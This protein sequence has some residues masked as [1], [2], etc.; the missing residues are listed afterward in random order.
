LQV[1]EDPEGA[2]STRPTAVAVFNDLPTEEVNAK[3]NLQAAGKWTGARGI[4]TKAK[5]VAPVGFA[6][7][8]DEE[9]VEA[10]KRAPV[11]S[12]TSRRAFERQALGNHRAAAPVQLL[13]DFAREQGTS[14]EV[15][16]GLLG[17]DP[18]PVYGST[19]EF[20]FEE[21]RGSAWFAKQPEP[22]YLRCAANE[23]EIEM[24]LGDS[25]GKPV[26]E[27]QPTGVVEKAVDPSVAEGAEYTHAHGTAQQSALMAREQPFEVWSQAEASPERVA[28]AAD[29]NGGQ[30]VSRKPAYAG[31]GAD[32]SPPIKS[33]PSPT[34][35][36]KEAMEEVLAMF[37]SVDEADAAVPGGTVG[38]TPSS[39]QPGA[40][41]IFSDET[42]SPPLAVRPSNAPGQ[43]SFQIF[44]DE[45]EDEAEDEVP[46]A[47][48]FQASASAPPPAVVAT[49][50][51]TENGAS[52]ELS[53]DAVM[54]NLGHGL[55]KQAPAAAAAPSASFAC[56]EDPPTEKVDVSF[57]QSTP[58]HDA[59]KSITAGAA[60]AADG[61]D[62]NGMASAVSQNSAAAMGWGAAEMSTILETSREDT[63]GPFTLGPC[64]AAVSKAVVQPVAATEPLWPFD[65]A[66]I[67]ASLAGVDLTAEPNCFSV[68]GVHCPAL[69]E[70]AVLSMQGIDGA[71]NIVKVTVR[72]RTSTA[73]IGRVNAEADD[74][75]DELSDD[76]DE[77]ESALYTMKR[78]G[79]S[80]PWEFHVLTALH[81]RL[82]SDAASSA[83]QRSV[84]APASLHQYADGHIFAL[85]HVHGHSLADV[86]SLNQQAQKDMPEELVMFYTIEMLRTL[87]S[88]HGADVVHGN[89]RAASFVLRNDA[90]ESLSL[91][92]NAAG[93]GGWATQG[94]R[95]TGFDDSID[96]RKYP[97]GQR[98]TI[99]EG[100]DAA[101]VEY[102][103]WS[104]ELDYHGLLSTVHA[105]LHRGAPLE[106]TRAASDGDDARWAPAKPFRC[107]WKAELWHELFDALLNA[108]AGSPPALGR[109]RQNFETYF[110]Q[111]PYKAKSLKTLL[112]KQEKALHGSFGQPL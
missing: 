66:T 71:V 58:F 79:G 107:Y 3:E 103:S 34:I 15:A 14:R 16:G 53:F 2:Q 47:P 99:R 17:Y 85:E 35:T 80:S 33:M 72:G 64:A 108:T 30:P 20:S 37:G 10:A 32:E 93:T 111:N 106:V 45:A 88:L 82:A 31:Y 54:Q 21:V 46:A 81:R 70:G 75:D 28:V 4:R 91:T 18:V 110:S 55:A 25:P 67:D 29:E 27:A 109:L 87:D 59:P 48:Q 12:T 60:A 100:W 94:L 19:E 23:F 11:K 78:G 86:V 61:A 36:S 49:P 83:V 50:L 95:L 101:M 90:H 97:A 26:Q 52:A 5:A 73:A 98:F 24:D 74:D 112:Q 105:M 57:L 65:G 68:S 43:G 42:E 69:D 9:A 77:D 56:F 38:V 8:Q 92:Y 84:P 22:A 104:V 89:F 63:T 44:S 51:D 40:F 62:E 1:F 41:Q 13:Q 39:N 102:D 7:F 6:V 96:L 76:E